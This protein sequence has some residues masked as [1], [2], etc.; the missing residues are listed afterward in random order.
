MLSAL[1]EGVFDDVGAPQVA[2]AR[3]RIAAE[4]DAHA[5]E[6]VAAVTRTGKCDEASRARL[7]EAV[8]ALVKD[9]SP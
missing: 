9:A 8:R 3:R 6:T 7:I 4:L 2:E 1:G 5:A